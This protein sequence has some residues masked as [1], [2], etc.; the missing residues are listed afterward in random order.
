MWDFDSAV[1]GTETTESTF[2]TKP[3]TLKEISFVN[4]LLVKTKEKSITKNR[5]II[6]P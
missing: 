2:V 3:D 5:I 4:F 6:N 1:N